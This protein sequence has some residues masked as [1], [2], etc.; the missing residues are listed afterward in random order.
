MGDLFFGEE[1]VYLEPIDDTGG[2]VTTSPKIVCRVSLSVCLYVWERLHGFHYV[3][4]GLS[5]PV[6][7]R[8]S[9]LGREWR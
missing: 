2:H 7:L 5:D 6:N 1:L 8:T 4:E 3:P 9:G